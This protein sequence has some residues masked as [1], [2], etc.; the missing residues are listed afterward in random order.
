MNIAPVCTDKLKDRFSFSTEMK[1]DGSSTRKST[2]KLWE[3]S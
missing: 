2:V 3:V 1:I